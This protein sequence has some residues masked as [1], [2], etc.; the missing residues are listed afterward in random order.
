MKK[1]WRRIPLLLALLLA[2]TACGAGG[3][4]NLSAMDGKSTE[5]SGY[6]YADT[7]EE[8]T[9]DDAEYDV[10]DEELEAQ[11]PEGY[12]PSNAKLIYTARLEMEALDFDAAVDGLNQLMGELGGY[13]ESSNFYN[14][15]NHRSADYT[16]R[17]PS[18]HYRAFLDACSEWENCHLLSRS[19][20]VQ[21]VGEEYFD[22][23]SRLTTLRT[24]LDRLQ[25]LLAQAENME[26]I[27]TIESAISE[28][29]YQ[30]EQYTSQL[31]HYDSLIGY[32]TVNLYLEEVLD[33]SEDEEIGLGARLLQNLR[34]GGEHF[35]DALEDL[36]LWAAY[37]IIGI[38]IF[39]VV[40]IVAVKL[41][42]K[43]KNEC[44]AKMHYGQAEQ[45]K[46]PESPDLQQTTD[47]NE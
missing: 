29:E 2:L 40:L 47:K 42:R 6:G 23:E 37:N 10:A 7:N 28:T 13:C 8:A 3:A 9:A 18:E 46:D 24:K 22:L 17:V 15:G 31:N 41:I 36:T 39:L 43:R 19:E 32:S 4:G 21:D 14:Y 35:L 11:R 5:F 27:I 26:D 25:E 38:V 12:D 45:K 16:V 33:L 20:D 30:I 34:W 44:K 1:Q